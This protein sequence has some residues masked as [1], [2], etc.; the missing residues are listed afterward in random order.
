[1]AVVVFTKGEPWLDFQN[2][3]WKNGCKGK[4]EA[5]LSK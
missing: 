1:M 2:I 5:L 4:A 3:S